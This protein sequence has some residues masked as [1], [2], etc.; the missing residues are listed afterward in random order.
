MGALDEKARGSFPLSFI[1][2]VWIE[3]QL[4]ARR[5]MMGKNSKNRGAEKKH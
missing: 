1:R 4:V 5:L 3:M 2:R